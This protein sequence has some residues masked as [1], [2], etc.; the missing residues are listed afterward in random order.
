MSMKKELI[1]IIITVFN[2]F[3]VS[4]QQD[5]MFTHYMFNTMAINPAYAGSR[6]ALTITALHRSQWVAFDGAPTT[7]TITAHSPVFNEKIGLGLS[8]LNDKIGISNTS[9]F[10]IDFSYKIR[11]N[12][13]AKLAFGLKSGFNIRKT[14]IGALTINEANDPVFSTGLEKNIMPN[15]GFGLYYFTDKYYAGVSI[16]K[17][18]ENTFDTG[19]ETDVAVE[20]KHYFLIGGAAFK[21]SET[22]LLRPATFVK[23][24]E[25]APIEVDLSALLYVKEKFWVGI[26]YRTGD[27]FGA[28]VGVN[29]TDYLSVGYSF[30]ASTE[31]TTFKYNA[32][33]HEIIIRYDLLFGSKKKIRSPR[34]F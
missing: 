32:G 33:S 28:L 5:P 17:L 10:Y 24:T 25:A 26:M 30:D 3:N 13:R 11:I 4:A 14:D 31:N 21:L 23:I 27:A 9:S 19:T 2:I 1:I 20:K 18:L 8:F 6:D 29:I 12:E 7:Q 15:F 16:P 34:Y 22:F